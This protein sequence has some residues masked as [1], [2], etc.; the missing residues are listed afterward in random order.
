MNAF[1]NASCALLAA[2]AVAV[3]IAYPAV[4]VSADEPN[5]VSTSPP[6][7]RTATAAHADLMQTISATGTIEPEDTVDVG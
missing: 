4:S 5:A 7:F 1:R 3:M 2:M 6:N